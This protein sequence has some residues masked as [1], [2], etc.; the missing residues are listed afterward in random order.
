[1][2]QR[3]ARGGRRAVLVGCLAVVVAL[4]GVATAA[5]QE[6]GQPYLLRADSQEWVEEVLW[7]GEGDVRVSY[8]DI[9]IQCDRIQ[10]DLQTGEVEAEGHVILDQGPSRLSA[11]RLLYNL[12]S[13][14]GRL[15]EARG[16]VA[17]EYYITGSEIAKLDETRY[18]L[19]D[20][21]FT[22]CEQE[23]RPPWELRARKAVIEEEGYGRFWGT[24]VWVKG[25][26][27]FYL[28]YMVWPVKQERTFG[29]LV[30]SMGYSDLRGAYLGNALYIPVGRSYDTTVTLDLFSEGYVG[31]GSE[32]RWA[33]VEGAAG[34]IDL[35]TVRDPEEGVWQWRVRGKHGQQ[36]L[37]GFRLL[38]EVDDLS[39]ID[40]FQEFERSYD[41]NTLRSLYS[42][43]YLTRPWG[44]GALNLRA[45][46][47][48]TF[49]SGASD[50][51][52]LSQL[53]ELELRV[54][55]TRVGRTALYWSMVSSA[56]LFD[57]DRGNGLASTYARADLY[58]SLSYTLPGPPW[59]TVTPRVG[60]RATYYTQQYGR[61]GTQTVFVD[62]PLLRANVEG[63]IDLVGPSVSR[64]FTGGLGPYEKLKHLIEPRIQYT[65][66][67]APDIDAEDVPRFDEVD[68]LRIRNTVK[69]LLAN[70]L[71]GRARA[72]ASAVELGTF[73]LFQEYSFA[74]PLTTGGGQ[75]SQSGPLNAALRVTPVP[76]A[77]LDAKAAYDT[78]FNG[79]RSTSVTGTVSA[80]GTYTGLTWYSGYNPQTGE[81][82]S[83]Q[84]RAAFQ[85]R[86]TDFPL[87]VDLHVG[88]DLERSELQ[89]QRLR[90]YYQGSCWGVEVEYRD[91]RIGAYPSRDYRVMID[92]KGLGRML[93]I[94][95]GLGDGG[96]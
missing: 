33:P 30:P 92:L 67:S 52:L 19:D 17:P 21:T 50:E 72:T 77:I 69:V 59:L 83:S 12:R 47:R 54:P 94:Q 24:S 49:L 79:L 38:A 14:T 1:V 28:P 44:P 51:I 43:V 40:F 18:R 63:A 68:S 4:F 86:T 73:E 71:F 88:Y 36:D 80:A 70:R 35:Y 48:R 34:Q 6:A 16:R 62:E 75:T 93:E 32:W 53:P 64:V 27:I 22:S 2:A 46:R 95:G 37:L 31:V 82:T 26:P 81:R 74:E 90:L 8:Q 61:Q 7:R 41:Q 5:G 10:L 3:R 20:A 39:D 84:L 65:Y 66:L 89:Q 25:A 42:Y 15:V 87:R 23:T 29:L 96:D 60:G 57:V 45:D 9:T 13:K 85:F 58:P 55:A 76:G 11:D 56:N 91:L 78:L